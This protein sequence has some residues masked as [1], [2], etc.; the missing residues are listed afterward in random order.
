MNN[1]VLLIGISVW[2][3]GLKVGKTYNYISESLEFVPSIDL[4]AKERTAKLACLLKNW[5]KRW[6]EVSERGWTRV[7]TKNILIRR[8][9]HVAR[10]IKNRTGDQCVFC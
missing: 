7:F 9:Y 1:N 5:N 3:T 10:R 4:F 6:N 8:S 2:M